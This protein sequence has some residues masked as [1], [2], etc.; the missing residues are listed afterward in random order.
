MEE[1][2]GFT[3]QASWRTEGHGGVVA[4]PTAIRLRIEAGPHLAG[5]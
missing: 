1:R 2:E 5:R 3:G 4:G